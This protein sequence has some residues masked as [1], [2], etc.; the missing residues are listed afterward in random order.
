LVQELLVAKN[1]LR[2]EK[3]L[4]KLNRNGGGKSSDYFC[5]ILLSRAL[6]AIKNSHG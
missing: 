2:L 5:F 6:G 4:K 3:F 1:E